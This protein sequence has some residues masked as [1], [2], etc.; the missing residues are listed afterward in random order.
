MMHVAPSDS[1]YRS[2]SGPGSIFTKVD[3]RAILIA[4]LMM[5][6]CLQY[7]LLHQPLLGDR[8]YMLYMGQAVSRGEAIYRT[9][10]FGYPP[11]GPMLL[12]I[13][14]Q[15]GRAFGV[16]TYIS[17]RLAGVIVAMLAAGCL[18]VFALRAFRNVTAALVAA[19]SLASF[20]FLGRISVTNLEP[21]ALVMLFLLITAL[22]I[23]RRHW[24]AAG[25]GA[26]LAASCWQ[27]AVLVVVALGAVVF[28]VRVGRGAVAKRA[29]A[30]ATLGA[31]PSVVYVT[32]GGSWAAF[33]EQNL[34][35]KAV[36][37]W[38]PAGLDT[39]FFNLARLVYFDYQTE[40]ALFV[41]AALAFIV[42]VARSGDR[43]LRRRRSDWLVPRYGGL[44]FLTVLA[45]AYTLLDVQ[46]APDLLPWLPLVGFWTAWGFV[47]T[48]A[49][50]RHRM[51]G[52]DALTGVGRKSVGVVWVALLA[53]YGLVDA[54]LY[55]PYPTFGEQRR[56]VAE[57]IER[58]G[59]DGSLLAITAPSIYAITEQRSPWRYLSL[60]QFFDPLVEWRQPAGCDG[61]LGQLDDPQWRLIVY[62]E[63]PHVGRCAA[64]L[65]EYLDASYPFSSVRLRVRRSH[66]Y[67]GIDDRWVWTV[68]RVYWTATN[69]SRLQSST[70]PPPEK[71]S[72]SGAD[73]EVGR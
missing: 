66:S 51:A 5:A 29:A 36:N 34:A 17:A 55:A 25:A 58:A 14:M 72:R 41:I 35:L 52:G 19:L 62:G 31:L 40:L 24:V 57:L 12:A 46:A 71:G 47:R 48:A 27:P 22:T 70:T 16:A 13:A 61:L 45:I 11:L 54:L 18:Y 38:P 43:L 28:R 64:R 60:V 23:Q 73:L 7:G 37:R 50:L 30:G 33:L 32:V 8:A 63:R 10:T 3:A 65:R 9:T 21:K 2:R 49:M 1:G 67:S 56:A 20:G 59:P 68:W 6:A 4:G 39:A 42:F 26:V 15:L 44:P 53:G 69:P